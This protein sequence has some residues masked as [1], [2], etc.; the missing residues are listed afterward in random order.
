MRQ[1]LAGTVLPQTSF[2]YAPWGD[3]PKQQRLGFVVLA[4][5]DH[6]RRR[7][8]GRSPA[9]RTSRVLYRRSVY[10]RV[11]F[12]SW[13]RRVYRWWFGGGGVKLLNRQ[14]PWGDSRGDAIVESAGHTSGTV[15]GTR[16]G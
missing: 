10:R 4:P 7:W 6:Y 8:C 3:A 2:L 1:V 15:C 16:Y 12:A 9:P 5:A 11:F 14:V 13:G